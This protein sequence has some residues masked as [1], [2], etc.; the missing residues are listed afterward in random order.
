MTYRLRWNNETIEDEI[1]THE[2]AIY[3]QLEYNLAYHG[4]VKIEV[5]K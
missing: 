3:L 5:I 2:E 4:G 1:K